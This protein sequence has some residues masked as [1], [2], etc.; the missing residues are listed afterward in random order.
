MKSRQKR[1]PKNLPEEPQT[2]LTTSKVV[3]PTAPLPD[4]L[5]QNI[6]AIIALQARAEKDLSQTQR[7][8]EAVTA[9]F[10]VLP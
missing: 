6:E 10:D 1:N 3:L 4:P 7:V 9:F 2:S 5:A 8:V